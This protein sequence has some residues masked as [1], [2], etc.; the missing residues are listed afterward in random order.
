MNKPVHYPYNASKLNVPHKLWNEATDIFERVSAIVD[1]T[2]IEVDLSDTCD[3]AS[4]ANK[5]TR[6]IEER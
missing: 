6:A 5:I 3:M 2:H 1:S 4:R